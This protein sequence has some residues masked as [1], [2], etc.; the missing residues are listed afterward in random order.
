MHRHRTICLS[1]FG[2]LI[3]IDL[4]KLHVFKVHRP[5][6]IVPPLVEQLWVVGNVDVLELGLD[7]DCDL[8]LLLS[9][10]L[11]TS[12]NAVKEHEKTGQQ[13]NIDADQRD[14][15]YEGLI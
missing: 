12:S 6:I 15:G 5:A 14:D 9:L 2:I 8:L 10:A 4:V 7:L 3:L 1:Y 13:C 11:A